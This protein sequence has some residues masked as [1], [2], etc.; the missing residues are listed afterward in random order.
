MLKNL[1]R[2]KLAQLKYLNLSNTPWRSAIVSHLD[3]GARA[4]MAQAFTWLCIIASFEE[5]QKL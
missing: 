3:Y 1:K 4:F 2:G 5:A